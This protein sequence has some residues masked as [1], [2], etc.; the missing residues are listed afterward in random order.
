MGK[1]WRNGNWLYGNVK[2]WECRDAVIWYFTRQVRLRLAERTAGRRLSLSDVNGTRN[3]H[4]A[5]CSAA[6]RGA[7]ACFAD[8]QICRST[9]PRAPTHH[10]TPLITTPS[11]PL[12]PVSFLP[13]VY[14]FY[15]AML[16]MRGTSH[17]PVSVSVSLYVCLS[18]VGIGCST[19]THNSSG[20]LV[21]WRQRSPRNSPGVTPTG[22][23]NAGAVCQNRRLS[24]NNWLYL[25]NGTR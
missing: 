5:R 6:R 24:T 17:G 19:K 21:F 23:P 11:P 18:Q 4:A 7:A 16:C 13:I 2:E 14:S 12:L 8:Q 22:T 10:G 9:A 25:E 15:R 20:S 3:K 1:M